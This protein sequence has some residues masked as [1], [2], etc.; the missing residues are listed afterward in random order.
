M[1]ALM[2]A[3]ALCLAAS[4]AMALRVTNLDTVPHRVQFVSAG[5]PHERSIAPNA[6]VRFDYM[7]NGRL[8]LLS[9]PAPKTGSTIEGTGI[10]TKYIGNGRDQGIPADIADDYVIWPGGK[11]QLQRRMKHRYSGY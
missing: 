11:L 4:P 7:P 1:R 2:L 3:T 8:S 6:T 5:T 10:L 9:S